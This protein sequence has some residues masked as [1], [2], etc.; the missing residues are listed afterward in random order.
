MVKKPSAVQE[1]RVWSLGRED[2]LKKGMATC[3]RILAWEIPWAE[4]PG[5]LQWGCRVGYDWTTN[6]FDSIVPLEP[7]HPSFPAQCPL[8]VWQPP[9]STGFPWSLQ[10]TARCPQHKA[11]QAHLQPSLNC[12]PQGSIETHT[13]SLA[14]QVKMPD[15]R[16]CKGQ[17][18]KSIL[19]P[20]VLLWMYPAHGINTSWEAKAWA[21]LQIHICS[22]LLSLSTGL[23]ACFLNT[24]SVRYRDELGTAPK[25]KKFVVSWDRCM[26]VCAKLLQSCLTLCDSMDYSPLGSFVHGILQANY[27]SRLPCPPPGH[28]PNPGIKPMSLMSH[29]LAGG[30][31]TTGATWEAQKDV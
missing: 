11:F 24:C 5:R 7:S 6:T 17:P 2:P 27:W 31:F 30:F 19:C 28:L 9:V 13:C 29:A 12:L 23:G 20:S 21:A 1:T 25:T 22:W 4:E 16:F 14:A 8:C 15:H 3:S 18:A 26:C 10:P